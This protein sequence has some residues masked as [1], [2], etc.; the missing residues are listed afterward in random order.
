[1]VFV[2]CSARAS[3]DHEQ[4]DCERPLRRALSE[5]R[6]VVR[7]APRQIAALRGHA[8]SGQ[9]ERSQRHITSHHATPRH[10]MSSQVAALHGSSGQK[11]KGARIIVATIETAARLVDGMLRAGYP[12]WI[13]YVRVDKHVVD[14]FIDAVTYLCWRLMP[15]WSSRCTHP[16]PNTC[17]QKVMN[18]LETL[19]MKVSGG[20]F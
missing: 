3:G 13:I 1:M 12:L 7:A 2:L 9:G 17:F 14:K 10:I 4:P 15:A 6:G 19:R 18:K 5:P 11:A 16:R 8:S 20:F